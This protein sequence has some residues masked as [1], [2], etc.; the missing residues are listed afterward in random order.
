M[1]SCLQWS[2]LPLRMMLYTF[3]ML[4]FSVIFLPVTSLRA[5]YRR[6]FVGKATDLNGVENHVKGPAQGYACQIVLT[7]PISNVLLFQNV[8]VELA[9][10][11]QI[12]SKYVQVI[13][14]K[15]KPHGDFPT[16]KSIKADHYVVKNQSFIDSVDVMGANRA[17]NL[18]LLI[19]VWN[20][21]EDK[22]SVLHCGLP[23][24]NWDG[25][26]CFNF[27][28]EMLHRY[29]NP[30]LKKNNIYKLGSLKINSKV[31]ESLDGS[32]FLYYLLVQSPYAV[33]FNTHAMCWRF[34]TAP[35]CFGGPG[36]SL[37]PNVELLNFSVEQS[38]EITIAA[39][40]LNVKPFAALVHSA[41][42]AHNKVM[43]ERARRVITQVSMQTRAYEPVIK[44]R[45]I[46]GDWLVGQ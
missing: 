20:N 18:A 15:E 32:S 41:V 11:C 30:K 24:A 37:Q 4:I 7:K 14:E 35:K 40:I 45:N 38:N 21:D 3:Y 22:P 44:E 17:K 13:F 6:C 34:V 28:K 23:G 16:E 25:T 27:T 39:K 26:S 31:K 33:L 10:E 2:T 5:I 29:S 46:I 1:S 12:D 8:V 19:R 42:T 9:K 36:L 43:G